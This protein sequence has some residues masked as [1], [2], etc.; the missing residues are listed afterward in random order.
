M[1]IFG[2]LQEKMRYK[3]TK[4][5]QSYLE[6]L[7]LNKEDITRCFNTYQEYK[8]K[9][10]ALVASGSNDEKMKQHYYNEMQR[11]YYEWQ[12]QKLETE[13]IRPNN[14]EEIEQRIRIANNL[15]K[16][17]K[18]VLGENSTLRFHGTPIYMAKQIINSGNISSTADRYDGYIRSTDEAGFCSASTIENIDTTVI[19]FT[20][21]ASFQRDLPCGVL[22]V[23][24]EKDGDEEYRYYN[25]MKNVDFIERPEQLVGICCTDE[26]KNMVSEWCNLKGVDVNKVFTYDEFIEYARNNDLESRIER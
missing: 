15:S 14:Q 1:S 26:V 6:S 11:W 25:A 23:L 5:Y 13:F 16:N 3:K 21:F 8:K 19:G 7:K 20:D 2:E 4:E 10:E 12:K 24:K 9:L 22:F 17:L 18:E